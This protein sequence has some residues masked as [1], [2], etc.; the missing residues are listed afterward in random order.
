M[1]AGAV[2]VPLAG[3]DLLPDRP[4]AT[5]PP[6]TADELLVERAT[7]AI[8]SAR[9]AAATAGATAVVAV[10]EAHLAALGQSTPGSSTP[11]SSTPGSST[12]GSSAPSGQA[13]SESTSPTA[14]PGAPATGLRSAELAL[15][16]TLT[17]A[18]LGA[19]DG[20]LARLLASMAAATAQ[21]VAVLPGRGSAR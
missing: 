19:E 13:P 6:P 12:P 4:A 10:H 1:L 8:R 20:G 9:D 7:A 18:S 11:G 3:C 5:P 21:Q 16:A 17:E 14:T 2:L 15:E